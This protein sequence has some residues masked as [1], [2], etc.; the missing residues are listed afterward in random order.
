[1][2]SNKAALA[3]IR[4]DL[5]KRIPAQV[6]KEI[7]KALDKS[8]RELAENARALAPKESG[9]LA[10]SIR[11]EPGAD[12]LARN[13]VAGDDSAP[14]GT[15]IEFGT[16]HADAEPFFWPVFRLLEKRRTGQINRAVKKALKDFEP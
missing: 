12:V 14:Q 13:V 5:L 9:D 8:A 11:V 3:A 10:D 1:M 7:G 15:F 2:S 6:E 16:E 4:R